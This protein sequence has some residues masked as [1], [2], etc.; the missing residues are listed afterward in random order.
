MLFRLT[1]TTCSCNN[2]F[3]KTLFLTLRPLCY[4]KF[5]FLSTYINIFVVERYNVMNKRLLDVEIDHSRTGLLHLSTIDILDQ[6][7]LC[8]WGLS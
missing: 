3:Q 1:D 5:I 8:Y 4:S 7:I 6:I 2:S